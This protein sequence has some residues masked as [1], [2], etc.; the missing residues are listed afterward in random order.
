MQDSKTPERDTEDIL[1]AVKD[2][3]DTS[4]RPVHSYLLPCLSAL[5]CLYSVSRNQPAQPSALKPEREKTNRHSAVSVCFLSLVFHCR[6]LFIIFS[7]NVPTRPTFHFFASVSLWLC[8]NVPRQS[9]GLSTEEP[10]HIS[11]PALGRTVCITAWEHGRNGRQS[12]EGVWGGSIRSMR[13]L[14]RSIRLSS[15]IV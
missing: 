14:Y 13:G 9:N 4:V 11:R 10:C 1:L 8:G 2:R 6:A 5:I 3:T 7:K 15:R 12:T